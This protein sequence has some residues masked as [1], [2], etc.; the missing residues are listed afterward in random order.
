MKKQRRTLD[1]VRTLVS[2]GDVHAFYVSREWKDK[3]KEILERD[4]YECQRCKGLFVVK[5]KPIKRFKLTKAKYVHHILPMK[6]HFDKALN[7]DNLVSL[8][9][10]CH[11]IVEG[12]D[13]LNKWNK[14]KPKLTDERW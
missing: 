1:E 5:D 7:D 9:F 2:A 14:S 8:C 3:R 12:R 11:E 13:D 4:H 6:E 10:H